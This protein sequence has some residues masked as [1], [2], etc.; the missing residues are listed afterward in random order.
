MTD[1]NTRQAGLTDERIREI[2]RSVP[3]HHI[4]FAR[5][6]EREVLAAHSAD[7]R[8]GERVVLTDEQRKRAFDVWLDAERKRREFGV[9][10]EEQRGFCSGFAAACALFEG[11]AAPAA[12]APGQLVVDGL[13]D[14]MVGRVL[15]SYIADICDEKIEGIC[16]DL[17]LEAAILAAPAAPAPTDEAIED[18]LAARMTNE[19]RV[20]MIATIREALV[21]WGSATGTRCAGG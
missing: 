20:P 2:H 7:A 9:N 3:N 6:I 16:H 18:F 5:A 12:P 1:H 10:I 21:K 13:T 17:C 15:R 8:N 19:G 4:D 14:E 11:L